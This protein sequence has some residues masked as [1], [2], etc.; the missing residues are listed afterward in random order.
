MLGRS[1][2]IFAINTENCFPGRE[3]CQMPKSEAY[4]LLSQGNM[5]HEKTA[6]SGWFLSPVSF[7]GVHLQDRCCACELRIVLSV[8]SERG[9]GGGVGRE[10]GRG[11]ETDRH[12]DKGKNNNPHFRAKIQRTSYFIKGIPKVHEFSRLLMYVVK[13]EVAGN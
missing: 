10:A 2:L 4:E 8:L 13:K 3:T 9:E 7:T 5:V 12:R 6:S 11:T 1:S